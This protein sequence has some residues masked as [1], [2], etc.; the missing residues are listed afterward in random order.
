MVKTIDKENINTMLDGRSLVFVGMMGCG[1]SAIGRLVAAELGVPYRDSDN[2]IT[3]AAD[4]TV[5]EI[6]DKFGEDY[7]RKGEE[8]VVERLLSENPGVLSLGGGAFVS[9]HT[10]RIIGRLGISIWLMADIDLLMSRIRRRPNSRPLLKTPNP[11]A[12]LKALMEER[13]PIYRKADI[14]VASSKTSKSRTRDDVIAALADWLKQEERD[15]TA[16]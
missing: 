16:G 14:H 1:K 8:R 3:A 7:F 15:V 12:T 11:R 2:E 4:M 10:R 6:F 9:E 5:P 13:M